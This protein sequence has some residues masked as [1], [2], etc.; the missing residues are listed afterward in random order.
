MRVLSAECR[1]FVFLT[2]SNAEVYAEGAEG[3]GGF[4]WGFIECGNKG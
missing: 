4:G 3:F 2:Q 1:N